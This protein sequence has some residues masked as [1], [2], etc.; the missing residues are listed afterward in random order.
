MEGCC[1]YLYITWDVCNYNGAHS[2]KL[3]GPS[4]STTIY[5]SPPGVNNVNLYFYT[6]HSVTLP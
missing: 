3:G 1:D 6:D 4:L 5:Y 2:L